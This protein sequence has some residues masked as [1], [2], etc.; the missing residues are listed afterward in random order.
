MQ[1]VHNR[2]ELIAGIGLLVVVLGINAW[3]GL[4][5]TQRLQQ[6]SRTLTHTHEVLESLA[7]LLS[8]VLDAE[9]AQRGS[10]ITD[11]PIYLAPYQGAREEARRLLRVAKGLTA[12]NQ[13]QSERLAV[14][15]SQIDDRFKELQKN[16]D[17]SGEEGFEAVR[18]SIRSDRGL[19][20]MKDIRQSI[21]TLQEE[22]RKLLNSRERDSSEAY[23]SILLSS[24]LSVL[25]GMAAVL[26]FLWLL[27]RYIKAVEKS[28]TLV[29]E[30]RQ[31]LHAMLISIGDG[32]IATD[33][34]GRITLLNHVAQELTGWPQE[35]A[36]GQPLDTVFKIV[37]EE[38]RASVDN[39]AQRAL[40]EGRIVG[41]AN[42][43][44]LIARNGIE[45]PIDD[46]AA[47]VRDEQG[48]VAGAILVFREISERKRQ[49]AQ[50]L[51]QTKALQEEDR[52][53]DEFLA[54]LAHELR[55]PLSPLSNALQIW[56]MVE[57]DRAQMDQ[58]RQMMERQVAQMTRLI[59]DLLDVARITRGKIELRRQVADLGVLI[60]GAVE[61][62]QPLLAA[63]NHRLTVD[64]PPDPIYVDGDVAR[65][66]QVFGNILNNAAKYTSRDGSIHVAARR[67]GET[68]VVEITDDGAGI[69]QHMLTQIFE[70]FQQV[71][72]TL[73][74]AHGGLGIGL[75]L[76]KRLVE[77]HGGEV[78]ARS[79]GPG[80]GSTI[81][82][83][84]PALAQVPESTELKAQAAAN[85]RGGTIPTLSI[86]V[87]D[88]VQAS[89]KT[90]AMMLQSI[91][92]KVSVAHDGRA[93]I[94]WVL[95]HRPDLVF[96][97]IAMPGM[98]GYDVAREI[99]SQPELNRTF[100]VAL[101]GY[102]QDAD[103]RRAMEAGFNHHMTKPASIDALEQ[104]LTT[105]PAGWDAAV[106][107]A[108]EAE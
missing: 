96:L 11:N 1:L 67:V 74:R 73:E 83:T 14:L 20:A 75:T 15:D 32:V 13:D 78:E 81:V 28:T 86:L 19:K 22:E 16:L 92:Q 101:T 98:S 68:A 57:A 6:H 39:P 56:P 5:Q 24:L 7:Q 18:E 30:H 26:S 53:K 77:L 95:A 44:I 94:E 108:H 60:A 48:Q 54:T 59:D 72:Q 52:R 45:W 33:A 91:G 35:E 104:L 10:I 100:L 88:D 93:A 62:V 49:E 12:D 70:M 64:L 8:A 42:H 9:S 2:K 47:P 87:V 31:L 105:R 34:Q 43:T 36:R 102:G 40:R 76:V 82:V 46:S 17:L 106:A 61:A 85:G 97:D 4:R 69:P 29:H 21:A 107:G 80:K 27:R 84:L 99:R 90:L 89:A 38:T 55:N 66:T 3:V 41:L 63:C 23:H 37:N 50:L 71:D 65:L 25:L 58:L 51:H 79:G 103:R